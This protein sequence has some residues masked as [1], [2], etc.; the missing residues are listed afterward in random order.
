LLD[1]IIKNRHPSKHHEV[2]FWKSLSERASERAKDIES[3]APDGM[4]TG[5]G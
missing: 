1:V 3:S 2:L 5:L 4:A